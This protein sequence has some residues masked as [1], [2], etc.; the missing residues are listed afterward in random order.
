M[1]VNVNVN[2]DVSMYVDENDVAWWQL[3]IRDDKKSP[4]P[5]PRVNLSFQLPV[6]VKSARQDLTT[7]GNWDTK[8][9]GGQVV[10]H[11]AIESMNT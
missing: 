9:N 7:T 1:N 11:T 8:V 10:G 5:A 3:V 2:V 4:L 6:V